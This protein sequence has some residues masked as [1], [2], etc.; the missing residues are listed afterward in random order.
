MTWDPSPLC[1]CRTC[2]PWLE[3]PPREQP[4]TT[5]R[6]L[7]T[8]ACSHPSLSNHLSPSQ[9]WTELHSSLMLSHFSI[10]LNHKHT[11]HVQ[12]GECLGAHTTTNTQS[13][14]VS[15]VCTCEHTHTSSLQRGSLLSDGRNDLDEPLV[16]P[17]HPGHCLELFGETVQCLTSSS[18][19]SASV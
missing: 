14:H 16:C 9:N 6:T 4:T 19:Q 12:H 2:Y 18:L 1:V 10:L 3:I 7:L 11:A 15:T 17:R 13:T 5:S 8:S